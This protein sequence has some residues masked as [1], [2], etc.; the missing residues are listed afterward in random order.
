MGFKQPEEPTF[1]CPNCGKQYTL[2]DNRVQYGLFADKQLIRCSSCFT[3]FKHE[4]WLRQ[5]GEENN[6]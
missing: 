6:R 4:F 2:S 3:E 1:Q 5:I